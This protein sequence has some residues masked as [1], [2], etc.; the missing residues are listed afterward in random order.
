MLSDVTEEVEIFG[1][2]FRFHTRRTGKAG[3]SIRTEVLVD[4]KVV[5]TREASIDLRESLDDDV[6]HAW[7]K[8]HHKRVFEVFVARVLRYQKRGPSEEETPPAPARPTLPDPSRSSAFPPASGPAPP[9]ASATSALASALSVRRFF[10]GFSQQLG[11]CS[12]L[13]PNDV[14]QQLERASG[15][16]D[17]M[18]QSPRFPEIRV[19][20]QA[21]CHLLQDRI[22][23]WWR[24]ARDPEQAERIWSEIVTFMNYLAEVNHR[25][26]LASFDHQTLGWALERVRSQG[27]TDDV[28]RQL[29]WLYGLL[30]GLNRLLDRP[31]EVSDDTWIA[32][33]RNALTLTDPRSFEVLEKE[34]ASSN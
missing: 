18:L 10:A 27:M 6:A 24:G 31:E 9:S 14:D 2:V 3:L 29:A 25:S 11:S 7:M 13:P 32:H 34:P 1:R 15:A 19:D 20:E 17:W 23:E 4:G 28:L 22:D 5:A 12:R 26:E 21:R 16:L 8:E 30:P 33:L